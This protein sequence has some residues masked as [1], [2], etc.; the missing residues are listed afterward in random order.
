MKVMYESKDWIDLLGL[1]TAM[2][3]AVAIA[4]LRDDTV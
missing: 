1:T 2:S 4:S 3:L